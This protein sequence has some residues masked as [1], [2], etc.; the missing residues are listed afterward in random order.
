MSRG[1]IKMVQKYSIGLDI[2]VGS[3]GWACITDDFRIPKFN[4]RYAL[5]TREFE[6]AE[7][8]E[9]RRIQRGTRRRYNR[10]IKR[11][12]LL[13]Q[14]ISPL[15]NNDPSFFMETD[16]KE[17]HFWR[18][19]NQFE[20]NSLSETLIRL[21]ENARKYPTIYH[22]R[23]ALLS[24][25]K[26]FDPKLIYLALHNLVKYRGHFLNE[27]MTWN[28][29]DNEKSLQVQLKQ[30]FEELN[31]H[32]Y[33]IKDLDEEYDNII[34]ILEDDTYTSSDKRTSILKIIG[35]QF[36]E[37]ITLIV[38][39]KADMAKLFPE[40]SNIDLYKEE[41]LKISFT[42]E[43][44][45]EVYEKLTDEEKVVID[46]ANTIY[47]NVILSD[48]LGNA[49]TVAEAKVNT[50]A[51]FS[52][53]LKLL[54]RIYNDYF[55]EKAYR[56]MFITCRKNQTEYKNT[57]N[58]KVL[59]EFD[60]FLKVK[61]KHEEKFYKNLIKRLTPLLSN[62]SITKN[63]K[64]IISDVLEKLERN[65]FLQKQKGFTNAA[66]PHQNNVFESEII[67]K[68]QQKYYPEITDEMIEKVK[69][70]IS[71]RIP[72]YI[73]PLVKEDQKGDFGWAIRKK[74]DVPVLP[75]TLDEVIDRS[76]SAE[77]F[78]NRMTNY[79]AYLTNEKVLPKHS[80]LYEQFEVLNEL[81]GIQIRASNDLPDKVHRLSKKE[82]KWI[83]EN[84]FQK[85]KT[86]T[87]NI[88]K[89]ELKKGPFK[90]LILDEEAD[91]LKEIYGTQKE[92]RFSTSLSSYIDMTKIF[93]K[94][95]DSNLKM[96]EELI[97]WITV[98][99]DRDIIRT[100]IKEKYPQISEKEI[101]TLIN[102]N[103]TG[104]GRLSKRLLN[105]LPADQ[106]N[107]LTILD[108]MKNESRVFME[109][110]AVEK[111]DLNRRI[112]K[113]NLRDSEATVKIKY[114]DIMDLQ[115]SPAIKKSIWQAI[116]II[117]ELVDIFGEPEN[118]MIEF[119]RE[120]GKKERT[121][122]RKKKITEL[123]KAVSR[124]EHEL[125]QFLRE[126]SRY[127]EADYQ[128]QRLYL[129]IIQ[130]GKCLYSGESLNI[131]RLQ[132]YEVDHIYPRSFV[133]DD[134]IDNLAL[135]KTDMNQEKG[136]EKMPLE[137]LSE[138]D[139][140]KQKIFWK[141]LYDNKLM[142]QTKYH[143]LMKESFS[144]QDKES[145]FARQLVETRQI[146]KHVKDLLNERFEKTEIHTVNADIVTNLR[147]HSNVPK[148][149][150]LN[151]K[152]HA[153]DAA[154]SAIVI[155]FII[156]KYG[157]N[158]LNFNFKFQEAQKKW[159]KMLTK[160]KDK[161]FLFSDID[162]YDKFI[163]YKTG[164]LLAGR[165]FLKLINDEIPW[166][167][168][169]KI[170]S[171]EA[172]FYKQTLFSPKQKQAKYIS[173][174]T[175]KGVYDEMKTDCTYL[176]SYKQLNKKGKEVIK[177]GFVDLYV[178]E[179]YQ[180]QSVSESEL[181]A[182]LASKISKGKILDAMIHSKIEKYQ[183]INYKG[184]PFYYVSSGEMHNAKQL[185]LDPLLLQE[186]YKIVNSKEDE[187]FESE[188]L[189]NIFDSIGKT[190]ITKYAEFLPESRVKRIYE[191]SNEID[192]KESFIHGFNEI[193][194]TTSA[195]AARSDL[196]G[197]RYV[198]KV[199][200]KEAKFVHQSITGLRY[201]KPKSYKNELWCK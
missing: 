182:Y 53:D 9:V 164:E 63:E 110:L 12:Q 59:C 116:L 151:N 54:K 137:I 95:N 131:T 83:I 20:N 146:T 152:H 112:A 78:I 144:D 127:E 13:Q 73:G 14:T 166:Q 177:S 180:L 43:D 91:T 88:L 175:S 30:L 142:S 51:Q 120:E 145:F 3:V 181:A 165:Q 96:I 52:K 172:A 108:I 155:Q 36:R 158:F 5:G 114:K 128:N 32:D 186:I 191:Y 41:K 49:Q 87:H 28:A 24:E 90:Y 195:S 11:I 26:S 64:K 171:G 46:Q 47:Q 184:H 153:V 84:V 74:N 141:K 199:S 149:R 29:S 94:I 39:L 101:K 2:G 82:K 111:Y 16:E 130:Q 188:L 176:I 103:Y 86:V 126:H 1:K 15:F 67:L 76:A 81:N 31:N 35:K 197:A 124:D 79:C 192:D 198:K 7:T 109:V 75:W 123:Q 136:N 129:Y 169:K 97:Y 58:E 135:V 148:L 162:K 8:A 45:A 125:K 102:L 80:L 66:I 55:G 178:I 157:H 93:G 85:R 69:D 50:Y 89:N 106:V 147:E 139:K 133:K 117:E 6:S 194:K 140:V 179:K 57:R 100:K 183:L 118:I 42:D 4:G 68:N 38:G 60:K 19:N 37:P 92:D 132:D 160:Y 25:D 21:G 187:E 23:Y 154:L 99:E 113:M 107:N 17:K 174:K 18:N 167:T 33:K 185:V 71:F 134:G 56:D 70:I 189:K 190:V 150:N 44:I 161:F 115:G 104:W 27:N 98:F 61:N 201:R 62:V 119:A 10:R 22:L 138:S 163:H 48:L 121:K 143:R 156:N 200:P 40:S 159:R 122:N 193:L 77:K 65:H 34:N 173:S 105:E 196:F 170:G 72:Y 168:T